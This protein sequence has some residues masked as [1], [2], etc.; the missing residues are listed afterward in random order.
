MTNKKII[1]IGAGISGLSAGCYGQMNG[2]ETHIF[3]KHTKAGGLC[4]SW[5]RKGYTI[6]TSG[7]VN[8]SGPENND[9]HQFWKELG[10]IQK[11]EFINY[12]EYVKIEGRD[13]Q[14]FTLYTDINQLEKH[15]LQLAPEDKKIIAEFIKALWTLTRYSPVPLRKPGELWTFKDKVKFYAGM[16]PHM[17]VL[18]KWMGISVKDF[19]EKFKNPFMREVWGEA[20][21]NVFF[22]NANIAMSFVFSTLAG[23]HLKNAGYPLGGSLAFVKHIEDRYQNLGGQLHFRSKVEKILVKENRAVGVVFSDGQEFAGDIVIS[24]ADGRTAIFDMLDGKFKNEETENRYTSLPLTPSLLFISLGVNR[25]IDDHSPSVGGVLFPLEEPLELEGRS[26]ELLGYHIYN[27]DPSLAPA[28]K[29]RIRVMLESDYEYWKNLSDIDKDRYKHE[30]E[31]IATQVIAALEK[32]YPGLS[33]QVEMCDVATPVSFERYTGSW[34]GSYL[35]W[36]ATPDF[37]N[38][39]I[40]KTLP[41]LGKF[42]MVGTWVGSGSLGFAAASGRQAIQLICH[43]D[44]KQFRTSIPA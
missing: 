35:G 42:Y 22:F 18:G 28:G 17:P 29:T 23:L 44:Q 3:E 4:T 39:R 25:V 36:L 13:G 12:E 43:S 1:I 6:G 5:K 27:F 37:M 41:G 11:Q 24:A 7:W 20:A 34:K 16:I 2:Y 26:C 8:G 31:D 10:V 21:P 40:G 33:N 14:E 38:L 30:Q 19:A 15:M 32:R 9:F